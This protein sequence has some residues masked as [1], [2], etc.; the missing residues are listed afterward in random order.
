[1]RDY[2]HL[3]PLVEGGASSAAL[4]AGVDA[5]VLRCVRGMAEAVAPRAA[6]VV[7]MKKKRVAAAGAV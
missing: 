5:A 3:L 6:D 7:I 4:E 1:M 2:L